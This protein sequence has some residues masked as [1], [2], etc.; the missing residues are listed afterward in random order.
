M[1]PDAKKVVILLTD[2]YQ[3]PAKFDPVAPA[4]SLVKDGAEVIAVG[5]T[6]GVNEKQLEEIPSDKGNS[7]DSQLRKQ[8]ASASKNV[9]EP[10]TKAVKKTGESKG[11]SKGNSNQ[12][13][14]IKVT[15]Y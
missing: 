10:K 6:E 15:L 9:E 5:I 4:Q 7:G 13:H 8:A 12:K 2:G 1:R 11:N 14:V 3:N